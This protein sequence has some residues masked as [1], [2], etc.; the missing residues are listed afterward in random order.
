LGQLRAQLATILVGP[1][2]QLSILND[3]F[4]QD[5]RLLDFT[6]RFLRFGMKVDK[7]IFA[8]EMIPSAQT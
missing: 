1:P 7:D 2:H 3:Q 6:Q 5:Q 4:L 8:P